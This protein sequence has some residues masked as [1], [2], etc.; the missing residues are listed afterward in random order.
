MRK[1]L[2]FVIFATL[3]AG[4]NRSQP[5]DPNKT[6]VNSKA[7]IVAQVDG[8]VFKGDGYVITFPKDWKRQDELV[9]TLPNSISD[10]KVLRGFKTLLKKFKFHANIPS[11]SDKDFTA[12]VTI[13]ESDVQTNPSAEE[14]FNNYSAQLHGPN[15]ISSSKDD[16]SGPTPG[17]LYKVTSVSQSNNATKLINV[18]TISQ[19]YYRNGR[20]TNII[21]RYPSSKATLAKLEIDPVIQLVHWTK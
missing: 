12:T 8:E 13:L 1:V 4:C 19:I 3:I 18:D 7:K 17:R 11:L 14:F 16:L 5:E 10:D 15:D 2:G 21:Y 20:S 6:A 9:G